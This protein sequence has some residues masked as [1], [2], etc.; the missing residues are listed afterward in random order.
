MV[1]IDLKT[2]DPLGD[3]ESQVRAKVVEMTGLTKGTDEYNAKFDELK[4]LLAQKKVLEAEME[5]AIAV[6]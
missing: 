6:D 3:I 4:K 1:A 2:P 5:S